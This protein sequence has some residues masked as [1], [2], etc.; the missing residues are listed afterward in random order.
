MNVAFI[1]HFSPSK[2]KASSGSSPAG[3]LTQREISEALKEHFQVEVLS[4]FVMKSSKSWPGGELWVKGER[5]DNLVAIG[6]VN[7][8]LI[9][10]LIFSVRL[11]FHLLINKPDLCIQY[12][13]YLFENISLLTYRLIFP[14]TKLAIIIQDIHAEFKYA[15]NIRTAVKSALERLAI[16]FAKHFDILVPITKEIANQFNIDEARSFVF[17]GGPTGGAI[18]S[19]LSKRRK[20]RQLK[21]I[22]VFAG[23]LEPHNGVDKLLTRWVEDSID[24]ELHIFG[25]GSLEGLVTSSAIRSN[26]IIF[27]GFQSESE[28]FMWQ[29]QAKWL[30]CL[31]YSIGLNQDFFFP[32]KF[33]NLLALDGNILVNRFNNLPTDLL[34][35]VVAVD[36]E[37]FDMTNKLMTPPHSVQVENCEKRHEIL[38]E[39]YTWMHCIEKIIDRAKT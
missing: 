26:N 8:Y 34:H 20:Q 3:D 35:N 14:K 38:L 22:A 30:V 39:K 19:L 29:S 18:Q 27:Q 36:D 10:H 32:S 4:S 23:A 5:F 21:N 12:N 15:T 31:R 37:L 7:I 16:R 13:S 33:F 2:E 6:F 9:K 24:L 17:Q 25:S 28:V 1:G 11:F